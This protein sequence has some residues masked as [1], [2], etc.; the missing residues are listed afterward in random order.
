[1]FRSVAI[2]ALLGTACGKNEPAPDPTPPL[3]QVLPNIPLP[4]GATPMA[5]EAGG[6]AVRLVVSS[7]SPADTVVAFY[8]ATLSVPPFR[9]INEAKSGNLTS[10]Y[11]EQDGPPMWVTV[12]PAGT[13]SSIVTIAGAQVDSTK[14]RDPAIARPV[15]VDGQVIDEKRTPVT[16][17]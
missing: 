17:P 1:M 7:T 5:R 16:D 10:F 8:R 11:V 2:L 14:R 15:G 6:D 13:T 3:A 12:E 9:L 4:P